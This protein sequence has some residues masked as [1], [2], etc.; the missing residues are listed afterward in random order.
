MEDSNTETYSNYW[1]WV[2]ANIDEDNLGKFT[3]RDFLQEAPETT[4]A[5][6]RELCYI[7]SDFIYLNHL[8]EVPQ[9]VIAK[10]YEL[11]QYGVSKRISGGLR[12]L[13][14]IL[15]IPESNIS[16]V[17]KDLQYILPRSQLEITLLYYKLRVISIVTLVTGI[18]SSRVKET[19]ARAI[20]NL[21]LFIDSGG[22]RVAR[23]QDNSYSPEEQRE[24]I[25]FLK[26]DDDRDMIVNAADR[27]LKYILKVKTQFNY[28]DFD[29]KAGRR[30]RVKT[31]ELQE[32][33]K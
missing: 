20:Q 3:I 24:V 4:D 29:F 12:K 26:D 23:L 28:G 13:K 14:T 9:S 6:L 22:K 19:L 15:Q 11:S 30:N 5:L 21:Q 33:F 17:R 2:S 25:A 8:C 31:L 1:D 10:M 32:F 7:E 27:Y 18:E 16:I